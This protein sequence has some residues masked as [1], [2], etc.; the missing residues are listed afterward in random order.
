MTMRNL[1]FSLLLLSGVAAKAQVVPAEIQLVFDAS[2]VE[3]KYYED[4]WYKYDVYD[5]DKA[6]VLYESLLETCEEWHEVPLIWEDV[7]AARQF[8]YNDWSV[9][10]FEIKNKDDRYEIVGDIMRKGV[11]S[12]T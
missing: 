3:T 1:I 8:Y 4:G 10:L 12:N 11:A 5:K 9:V 6:L 2:N 7:T